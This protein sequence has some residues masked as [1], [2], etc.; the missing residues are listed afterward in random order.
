MDDHYTYGTLV[1]LT[2]G[3]QA[4]VLGLMAAVDHSFEID[5][6]HVEQAGD[7]RYVEATEITGPADA[8]ACVAY[9]RV[10]AFA[11]FFSEVGRVCRSDQECETSI[12]AERQR[13][14]RKIEEGAAAGDPYMVAM[15]K[16][17]TGPDDIF[18][19]PSS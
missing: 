17:I 3:S 12:A 4:R 18:G 9:G 16:E 11:C 15:S 2:D 7:R 13:V 6:Y 1:L 5:K 14:W 19:G 8:W 10:P